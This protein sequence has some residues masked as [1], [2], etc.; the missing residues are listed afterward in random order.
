[1][2]R[3]ALRTLIVTL[4]AVM[5]VT[6]M[7]LTASAATKKPGKVKITSVKYTAVSAATNK[8]TA[9]IKWKKASNAKKYVVYAKHGTGSWVKQKTLGKSAR[10]LK[11]VNVPAGQVSF[12]VRAVNKKKYGKYSAIKSKYL[13]SPLSLQQ[14]ADRI[15]PSMKTNQNG[16]KIWYS[17]NSMIVEYDITADVGGVELTQEQKDSLQAALASDANL[18]SNAVTSKNEFKLNCG[19]ANTKVLIRYLNNGGTVAQVTY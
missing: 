18:R 12:R 4:I 19:I 3:K 6:M 13:A 15:K 17:G 5:V 9:T 8:C 16:V 2:K 1:M 7:P 10:K 11:I 14:Y